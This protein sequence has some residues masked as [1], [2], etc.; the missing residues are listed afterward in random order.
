MLVY[1]F[2]YLRHVFLNFYFAKERKAIEDE[3]KLDGY[4]R[5]LRGEDNEEESTST[6]QDSAFKQPDEF[7]CLKFEGLNTME[8][9]KMAKS[10]FFRC[11]HFSQR[12]F[13]SH[14]R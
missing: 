4:L 13:W 14:Q 3:R 9:K 6:G 10:L 5:Y 11:Y 8:C 1:L 2:K 12:V 7:N